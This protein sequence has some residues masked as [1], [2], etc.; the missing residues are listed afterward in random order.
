MIAIGLL[1]AV[2]F[3]EDTLIGLVGRDVGIITETFRQVVQML[4]ADVISTGLFDQQSERLGP[5]ILAAV[6]IGACALAA[7]TQASRTEGQSR[8][9]R[10]ALGAATGLPFALLMLIAAVSAGSSGDI[11]PSLDGAFG[12]GLLWGALG[13]L[14]G[15]AMAIRRGTRRAPMPTRARTGLAVV[16][17]TLR[18]LGLLLLVSTVIGL[19]L[20]LVQTAAGVGNAVADR[21]EPVAFLEN[22]LYV[23]E[24]GLHFAELG[25]LVEFEPPGTLGA[26]GLPL[27]VEDVTQVTGGDRFR[28]FGYRGVLASFVFVPLIVV[29]TR[30]RSCSRSMRAS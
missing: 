16:T 12:Y 22:T 26:F 7:A 13:G 9:V 20:V 3:S 18:P 30:C 25:A 8:W 1:L 5:A 19:S 2:L 17:A 11:Q 27:P 24:H 28:I 15:T 6:P 21:S 14:A 4:L 23:L 29:G 10:L